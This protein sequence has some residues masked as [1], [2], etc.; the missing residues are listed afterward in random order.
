M[1]HT[2]R[3][4]V[5]A[6]ITAA[7]LPACAVGV[8]NENQDSV[9]AVHDEAP[10]PVA[11]P[12]AGQDTAEPSAR[13]DGNPVYFGKN[14]NL[15]DNADVDAPAPSYTFELV[16]DSHMTIE[17]ARRNEDGPATIGFTLHRAKIGRAHV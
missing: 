12:G 17:L 5:T 16:A 1:S 7:F 4:A 8:E 10:L 13:S 14:S 6:L 3:F 15:S 9:V 2:S 11:A